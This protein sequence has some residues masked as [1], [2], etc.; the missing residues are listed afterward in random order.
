MCPYKKVNDGLVFNR[1]EIIGGKMYDPRACFLHS[2]ESVRPVHLWEVINIFNPADIRTLL[3]F[4][5]Q[6]LIT[7]PLQN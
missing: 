1:P 7:S 6:Q 3:Y 2:A 4:S 5:L